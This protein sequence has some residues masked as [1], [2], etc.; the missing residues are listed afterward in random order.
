MI[1]I[2]NIIKRYK[3]NNIINNI[4]FIFKKG[5]AYSIIGP[6][7]SGKSTLLKCIAGLETINSGNIEYRSCGKKNIG[8]VFQSFNLFSNM[9]ILENVMYAPQKVLNMKYIDALL[10]ARTLLDEVNISSSIENL[11]PRDISGGQRQRVAIIRTLCMR[12]KVI[13]YDEPTSSLDPEN[14]HEIFCIIKNF[15]KSQNLLSI[16]VTHNVKLAFD[17]SN[18]II[19]IKN[20]KIIEAN[21]TKLFFYHKRKM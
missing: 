5:K 17:I 13:L 14:A 1:K 10:I 3:N 19:F 15:T 8:F 21:R 7:G 12:P 20:G 6:S 2:T 11:Y 16:I 4:S 9:T 18:S